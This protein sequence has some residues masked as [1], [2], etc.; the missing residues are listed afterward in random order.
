MIIDAGTFTDEKT[1]KKIEYKEATTVT[2]EFMGGKHTLKAIRTDVKPELNKMG[3]ALLEEEFLPVTYLNDFKR[4][5]SGFAWVAV[6]FAD[7]K[8][9]SATK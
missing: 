4:S 8:P 9:Y 6:A 3:V 7:F 1:Q 2:V 5:V